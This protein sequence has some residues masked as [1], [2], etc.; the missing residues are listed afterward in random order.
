MAAL[1]SR[2]LAVYKSP[3]LADMREAAADLSAIL[4]VEM[5]LRVKL[6]P[7]SDSIIPA[8]RSTALRRRL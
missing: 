4:D 8:R 1:A 5:D 3:K 6:G 7:R 2:A